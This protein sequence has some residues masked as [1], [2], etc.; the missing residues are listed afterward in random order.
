MSL[1]KVIVLTKQIEAKLQA[2]GAAG[3]GMHEKATSIEGLLGPDLVKRIRYLAS[4]R[5]KLVHDPDV[6]LS[7]ALLSEFSSTAAEVLDRLGMLL[8]RQSTAP[9]PKPEATPGVDL[10]EAWRDT[11]TGAK[12]AIVTG[13]LAAGALWIKWKMDQW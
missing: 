1:E 7:S 10:A 8:H 12:V 3:R 4:V 13:A 9:E 11:S 2:L 6:V 5:N